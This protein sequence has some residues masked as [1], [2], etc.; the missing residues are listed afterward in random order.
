MTGEK[1]EIAVELRLTVEEAAEMD[2][3]MT[4]RGIVRRA[5]FLRVLHREEW[6]RFKAREAA[7]N[8]DNG[9]K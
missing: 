7:E 3:M 1:R 4:D 5:S 6:K 9:G 2:V 8:P